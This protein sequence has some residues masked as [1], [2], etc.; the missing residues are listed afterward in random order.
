M[1][2]KKQMAR[3]RGTVLSGRRDRRGP[4]HRFHPG[5]IKGPGRGMSTKPVAPEGL[6]YQ[7]GRLATTSR[8][9]TEITREQELQAL[10]E[11]ARAIG[12]R[13]RLLEN[14]IRDIE[15]GSTPS[16]LTASVDPEMCVGCGTCQEVCPAGAISVEKI[17]RVDLKRCTG[18]GRCVGQCPRGAL[19]LHPLNTGY[20]EQACVAL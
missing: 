8:M 20:K 2:G 4:R 17:A 5:H 3:F 9:K 14:R 7:P 13:L 16:V 19:C 6:P 10:R 18:C 11:Q 15:P 12:A 1:K